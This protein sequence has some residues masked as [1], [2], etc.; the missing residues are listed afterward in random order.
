MSKTAVPKKPVRGRPRKTDEIGV[1]RIPERF[2]DVVGDL[3]GIPLLK[4]LYY[5]NEGERIGRE[6]SGHGE[7]MRQ[8][9]LG[10]LALL[11]RAA[12]EPEHPE[13][14]PANLIP[15]RPPAKK[16]YRPSG[17]AAAP[18]GLTVADA[19]A[20]QDYCNA[21]ANGDERLAKAAY[22]RVMEDAA[23]AGTLN[24][25]WQTMAEDAVEK[26]RTKRAPGSLADEDLSL[27]GGSADD[28]PDDDGA[29]W[30]EGR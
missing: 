28:G 15:F 13:E 29:E 26:A 6:G 23:A 5:L 2:K 25:R 8:I 10:V 9:H 12:K 18:P 30:D 24:S 4:A 1:I 19:K 22:A 14:L 7:Q 16:A 20:V 21:A 11:E 17:G 3:V 27:F